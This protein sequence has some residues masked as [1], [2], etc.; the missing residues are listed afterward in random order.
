MYQD[1][2]GKQI[3]EYSSTRK[4]YGFRTRIYIKNKNVHGQ[5]RG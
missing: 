3:V 1:K 5:E 2:K 4:H